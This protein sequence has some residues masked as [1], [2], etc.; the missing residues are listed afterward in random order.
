MAAG[1]FEFIHQEVISASTSSVDITDVFTSAYNLYCITATDFST[2]GTT[3][4]GVNAR[5]INSSGSVIS[6]GYHSASLTLADNATYV[7]GRTTTG[8]AANLFGAFDQLPD[9]MGS[10]AYVFNPVDTNY[11]FSVAHHS[12]TDSQIY[13]GEKQI[14]VLRNTDSITGLR[15]LETAGTNPFNTGKVTIYG[16]K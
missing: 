11:T 3:A 1:Y 15:V 13:R 10:I 5:Y 8:T 4:T 16:V 6:S 2:V 7:E 14:S 12:R 9:S